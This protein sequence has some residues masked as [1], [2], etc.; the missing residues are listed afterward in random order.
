MCG[1]F[2]SFIVCVVMFMFFISVVVFASTFAFS[3]SICFVICIVSFRVGFS[4]NEWNFCGVFSR[5]C[6]IGNVNV[7]VFFDFVCVSLMMLCL[8]SVLGMVVYWMGV[9]VC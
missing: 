5:F 2:F 8:C 3:V 1:F 9:G 6:S 4:I 7:F